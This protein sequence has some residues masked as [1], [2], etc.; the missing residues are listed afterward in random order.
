MAV[1]QLNDMM[2]AAQDYDGK[3]FKGVVVEN[4]DPE[5]LDRVKAS[6]PGLFDEGELPWIGCVKAS[7]F[8]QGPGF[9]VYGVP[10]KGSA[11]EI[12][13]QEGS[14]SHPI[15]YGYLTDRSTVNPE[16]AGPMV[17]GYKDPSGNKLRV[18][19]AAGTYE[20]TH[21]SG[22][23]HKIDNSGNMA[24]EGAGTHTIKFP[25]I[26]L[27]GDVLVKG[28]LD[29]EQLASFLAGFISNARAGGAASIMK[30]D[31]HHSDGSFTSNNVT[32]HLHI[33]NV[34]HGPTDPPTPG[35]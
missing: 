24:S 22:T 19:R 25:K 20:F 3:R 5:G 17:W 8:G 11:I 23:T 16:F 30:G 4:D 34:E 31:I 35:T 13:L 1:Q 27:D 21:Q 7:P 33:H 28:K 10:E 18:D 12:Q 26:V 29:V 9:G 2:G 6:V 15:S 32:V 14:A